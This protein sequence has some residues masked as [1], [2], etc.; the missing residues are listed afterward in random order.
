L[1]VAGKDYYNLLGV[2]KAASGDEIKA[3]FRKLAHQYH[4]DKPTGNEAKF[5]EINEAYQVLG[6]EEKRRKYDQFGSGFDQPGMG[7]GQGFGGFDFQGADFGDIFGEMFGGGRSARQREPRG[8][9]IIVDADLTFLEA[10][11]GKTL[12]VPVS[13]LAPCERC[14]AS[15]AE[16]GTE[17]ETCKTCGGAGVRTQTVRT[18]LGQMQTR[19]T[20]DACGGAGQIPK[21][22]C[23]TCEGTGLQRE[24]KTLTVSIPEGV[25]DGMTLRVRGEGEA[26]KNGKPGDLHLRLHVEPDNRFERDGDTI[27]TRLPLGF[28]QA[29]LGDT[30]DVETVDGTVELKVPAG[31]QGGSEFR[32]RGKGV[33]G[34]DHIVIAE[35]ITPKK[36]SKDQKRLLEEM[37]LRE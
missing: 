2:A 30:I 22:V 34:G 35:V 36:L 20:C 27:Y 37:D 16:P 8:A 15:G 26:V 14:R 19:V 6:N 21:Q 5:K 23:K 13:R 31:T 3:A 28:T 4:P 10:V 24:K 29:A 25:D 9:D 32:L 1:I 12:D 7:G 11:H 17:M 18:I 33:R